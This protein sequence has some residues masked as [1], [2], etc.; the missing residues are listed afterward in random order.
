MAMIGLGIVLFISQLTGSYAQAGVL[1]AVFQ[2]AAAGGAIMTSRWTDRVGQARTLPWLSIANAL[3]LVAFV[4]AVE[5]GQSFVVQAVVAA[6]AGVTQPAIGSMVR[7]RWAH[8]SDGPERLRSAFAIESIVDELIFTV[9]PLVTAWLAF[10]IGLPLPLIVAAVLTVAGSLALAA[11]RATAPPARPRDS[12]H[13]AQE[14][15]ALRQP[16]ML[17]MVLA[18]L[19]VGGVF[20]TYEVAVVAFS[21]A[22]PYPGSAGP[23]LGVWAVGSM[24]GGLYFGS[25]QWRMDLPRQVAVLTGILAVSLL[26]APFVRS[27]PALFAATF[28][29]AF[30][31]AP[32]LIA[33]FSLTERLV[34]APQLTEGLTWAN[35][36]LAVGYSLGTSIN[37]FV[38][39]GSG[40]TAAFAIPALCAAF[41][42]VVTVA[43]L[44]RLRR[45]ARGPGPRSP[46]IALN[47]EPVPGPA[48]GGIRD[49]P[50]RPR[51]PAS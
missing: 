37:G 33:I 2:L 25:R 3:G 50:D 11:Q 51:A 49:D 39:D 9:G 42:S 6:A 34:P 43:G 38:I 36:G 19:G 29:S 14:R 46:G 1:G 26:A 48:P 28:V 5:T 47:S 16:G 40:T 41:A 31:V 27:V 13:D 20:G 12:G 15:G 18:S 7:A 35:S 44:R 32:S 23:I 8:V 17:I 45:A 24:I 10:S 4:V 30:V 22:S 21:Q